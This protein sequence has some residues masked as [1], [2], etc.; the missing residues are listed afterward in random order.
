[1]LCL[2]IET[3]CDETGL[4]LVSDGSLIHSVLSSQVE[5]HDI[6]GGVVP[7]LASREHYRLIGVLLDQLLN[8]SHIDIHD[9]DLIC[10]ARGPGLLGSLLVGVNFAKGLALGLGRPFLGINHLHAHIM[11]NALEN[12]LPFPF[13]GLLVSGGHTVLYRVESPDRF[14]LIGKCLDD[15]AG[16]VFD[17]IGKCLGMKYPAGKFVDMLSQNVESNIKLPRP[18]LSNDNLNFSFSGLKTAALNHLKNVWQNCNAEIGV[19]IRMGQRDLKSFCAALNNAIVETLVEKTRRAIKKNQ[20]IKGIVV[21][22]GVAANTTLRKRLRKLG[23]QFDLPIHC[24]SPELCTDN[25]IMIAMGGYF[26]ACSGEVHN[27]DLETIPKGR[28]MPEDIYPSTFTE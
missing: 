19:N 17:K 25:G 4:A 18:F 10:A 26:L 11:I 12:V 8:K 13:I 14:I 23:E 21:A 5:L 16:E 22:G 24:P 3:S 2:G 1:M 6:F 7:E 27:L 28:K 9:L 20:D 15:A